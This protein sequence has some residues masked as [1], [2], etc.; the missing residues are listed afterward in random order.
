MTRLSD[1][2]RRER[3]LESAR[4]WAAKN[5]LAN[6]ERVRAQQQAHKERNRQHYR[7]EAAKYRAAN[8]ESTRAATREWR[9][10]NPEYGLMKN[11][12][13][14]ALLRSV[15]SES[16]TAA[17]IVELY[18][19]NC[20]L[21]DEP[22]DMSAPRLVGSEGWERSLHL[23]HLIPLVAGGNDLVSNIRPSHALCNLI[24]G[25]RV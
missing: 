2:E 12:E 14:R 6:P 8:P 19:S 25:G 10:A 20:H 11:R 7:D 13:K 5:R 3:R 16:Y 4:K 1:E 15:E 22:I 17:S 24:K 21:C 18:G 23:D 9:K